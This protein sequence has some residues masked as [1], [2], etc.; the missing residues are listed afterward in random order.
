MRYIILLF[1]V[2]MVG[3]IQQQTADPNHITISSTN[4]WCMAQSG[5]IFFNGHVT[6]LTDT[7]TG[8][9]IKDCCCVG[10]FSELVCQCA[11]QGEIDQKFFPEEK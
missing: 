1:M 10:Q 8:E 11:D 7:R 2:L 9:T 6:D 5:Q 4:S 3:C